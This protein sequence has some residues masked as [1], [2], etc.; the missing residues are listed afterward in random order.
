MEPR[1]HAKYV[2]EL[3]ILY[4]GS[5]VWKIEIPYPEDLLQGA[6]VGEIHMDSPAPSPISDSANLLKRIIQNKTT[7]NVTRHSNY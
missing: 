4:Y 1:H 3:K 6:Y 7:T 2:G 5:L